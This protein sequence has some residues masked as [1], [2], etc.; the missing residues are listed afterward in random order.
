MGRRTT[1]G[2]QK[3]QVDKQMRIAL[4][5]CS[6]IED[7]M[8]TSATIPLLRVRMSFAKRSKNK[9]RKRD[10]SAKTDG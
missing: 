10:G 2:G 3:S 5:W 4:T 7:G 6:I 1:H 9:E 8:T